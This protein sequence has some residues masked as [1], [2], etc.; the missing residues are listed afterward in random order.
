[1]RD[2]HILCAPAATW[3]RSPVKGRSSRK[4]A[5][6]SCSFCELMGIEPWLILHSSSKAGRGSYRDARHSAYV[7][8]IE[9]MRNRRS[10]PMTKRDFSRQARRVM[11]ISSLTSG[12]MS[13]STGKCAV[14]SRT[15]LVIVSGGYVA[16]RGKKQCPW[17]YVILI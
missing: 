5:G 6:P 12:M 16:V 8:P 15:V 14:K 17:R 2:G 1:M 13:V 3:R 11:T 7:H 9:R 4:L 10:T